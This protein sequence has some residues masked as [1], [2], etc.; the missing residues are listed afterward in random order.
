MPS[1]SSLLKSLI[2]KSPPPSPTP[3]QSL[4]TPSAP[5]SDPSTPS[6]PATPRS[7]SAHTPSPSLPTSAAQQPRRLRSLK[8]AASQRALRRPSESREEQENVRPPSTAVYDGTPATLPRRPSTAG[9]RV[10]GTGLGKGEKDKDKDQVE[11]GDELGVF[12]A[13][14]GLG[15]RG[16][17]KRWGTVLRK[18]IPVL[19]APE[20]KRSRRGRSADTLSA[21]LGPYTPTSPAPSPLAGSFASPPTSANTTTTTT[22][23]FPASSRSSGSGSATPT[24]STPTASSPSAG[25]SSPVPALTFTPSP[26]SGP[27]SPGSAELL[28][29]PPG[30]SSTTPTTTTTTTTSIAYALPRGTGSQPSLS[31]SLSAP[32]PK[33][34]PSALGHPFPGLSQSSTMP[35]AYGSGLFPPSAPQLYPEEY[36]PE[37]ETSFPEVVPRREGRN[38]ML[39]VLSW[40]KK[41]EVAYVPRAGGA[42]GV[43]EEGQAGR[44]G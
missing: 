1:I 22:T 18:P 30:F 32:S 2:K 42:G 39:S 31:H 20:E 27:A 3:R 23:T 25:I 34:S 33:P 24:P 28:T 29:P 14:N 36:A 37:P 13:G 10:G 9:A 43:R 21:M 16:T 41:L 26:S 11:E 38:S 19:L 8:R 4:D 40:G 6:T 12:G 44:R 7:A 15:R 5:S 35:G 17:V